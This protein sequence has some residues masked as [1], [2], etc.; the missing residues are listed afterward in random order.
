MIGL[1][2]PA[3]PD[4]LP[5]LFLPGVILRDRKGH[6][7]LERHAIL[8]ID[9]QKRGRNRREAQALLD[10]LRVH[11]EGRGDRIFGHALVAHGLEGAELIERMQRC[12]LDVLGE[13]QLVDQ[14][15]GMR[16]GQDAGHGRGLGEALLPDQKLQRPEAAPA[17]RHL[18]LSGFLTI[19]VKKRP[20]MQGLDQSAPGDRLGQF[21]DRDPGLDAP[22][23]RLAQHQLVEGNVARGRQRDLVNGRGHGRNSMTGAGEPLSPASNPSRNP[24]PTS[25]SHR[26]GCSFVHVGAVVR[27]VQHWLL[28]QETK[29][30]FFQVVG[31]RIFALKSTIARIKTHALQCVSWTPRC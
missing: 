29:G 27:Q 19:G 7:L 2:L 8:G 15:A 13:R 12:T 9:V 6:Q 16:L 31:G 17:R 14:D 3:V 5:D 23:V 28:L 30:G 22:D 21:L 18:E 1:L 10:D 24:N 20:D 25:N 11:E 26:G 4:R